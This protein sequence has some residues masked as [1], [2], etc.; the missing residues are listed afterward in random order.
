[1]SPGDRNF[2]LLLQGK[3][4]SGLGMA[5]FMVVMLLW[6]QQNTGS[7]TAI[8]LVMMLHAGA[9]VLF[10]PIGGLLAD[11]Y[12]RR[13]L[14]V[15][16]DLV[17]GLATLLVFAV[18]WRLPEDKSLIVAAIALHAVI[19]SAASAVMAPAMMALLPQL[20]PG[21]RLE[22]ANGLMGGVTQLAQMGG[23]AIA[24]LLFRLIGG[25]LL[26]LATA[27]G[28]LLS[29]LSELMIREPAWQ[30]RERGP[31]AGR[32]R[33]ELT[34]AHDALRALPGGLALALLF[35]AM[36]VF[37]APL[38]VAL[39]FY[40]SEQ[41]GKGPAWFGF[42]MGAEAA[43]LSFGGLSAIWLFRLAFARSRL[44]LMLVLILPA[45]LIGLALTHNAFAAM[46]LLFLIGLAQAL[47]GAI[48]LSSLQIHLPPAVLGR[49]M[50][51]LMTLLGAAAPLAMAPAGLLVD[52]LDHDV[53]PLL[54]G[55]GGA[56][57]LCVFSL[58]GRILAS[59]MLSASSSVP[60]PGMP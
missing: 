15:I 41:L 1:M 36:T 34:E 6:L 44:L 50:G 52:W 35:I 54:V 20:L 60:V 18:M 21:E 11:R 19:L 13:R 22:G 40:V 42:L 32:L 59:G 12:P 8:G 2:L 25:P 48:V 37:S 53:A 31:A 45:C 5:F 29:A 38:I 28:F 49:A 10:G 17:A 14:I 58:A 26:V 4:V 51:L 33:R 56:L 23:Q 30:P 27:I 47:A 7:G 24:G 46:A 39:P 57:G 55:C 3:L 16:S 43:G 9:L